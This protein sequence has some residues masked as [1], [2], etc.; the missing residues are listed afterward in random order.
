MSDLVKDRPKALEDLPF[1]NELPQMPLQVDLASTVHN[2][3]KQDIDDLDGLQPIEEKYLARA[4]RVFGVNP[5]EELISLYEENKVRF[6]FINVVVNLYGFQE[7]DGVLQGKPY[8]ISLKPMEKG[9]KVSKVSPGLFRNFD[10]E[11]LKTQDSSYIGFNPFTQ[12]F[13]MF[14]NYS[15]FISQGKLKTHSDMIGFVLNT[16]A[17]ASK[18]DFE[19]ICLPGMPDCNEYLRSK[20][21]KYRTR[22]Y[23]KWFENVRPRKVWGCDSPIELFLLHAMNAEGLDPEIQTGIFEDGSTHPSLHQMISANK[24]ECEIEQI[25]D[26]DFYFPQRKLAVFCDSIAHHRS[27][28]AKNKDAKIDEKLQEIGIDSL[29]IAGSDIVKNP[30]NC[31]ETIFKNL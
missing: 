20:F 26:A 23:F 1:Y 30:Y 17:L 28:K 4:G 9:G 5:S 29:R 12:G 27:G 24:R 16:F 21:Y 13:G 14:S 10:M 19:N 15:T 31:V 11:S 25:T 2:F 18:W 7:K 22:R 8:S 3:L 6:Q